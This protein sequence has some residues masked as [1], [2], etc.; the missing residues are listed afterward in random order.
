MVR[1]KM[2]VLMI[3]SNPLMVDPRVYKEAKTLVEEGYG[4]TVIVWDRHQEHELETTLDGIKIIRIHNKGLM[5]ILPNDIFRNP[6]WWR[7]AYRKGLKLYNSGYKFDVVH[8]HDLDTLQA[9]VWLKKKLGIK[10]IY[11][12]HELWGYLIKGNVP[13]FIVKKAF[14][15]E[16]KLTT[17]VDHII[18][19]SKP[20]KE[21]FHSISQ[22]PVTLVMN[23]KDLLYG[24]Y[25]PPG[26]DIFTLLYIGGMKKRR[27]FPQI[28]DIVGNLDNVRLVLGGKKEDMYF[29]MKKYSKK[30][31]NIEFIGTVPSN[32]IIP[33]TRNAD[34]TFII[35]DPNSIHY[36]NT[37]FNKQF[38][39][40]VCGRP[41][42][43]TKR[44]YAGEMTEGLKCGIVVEYTEE[45]VKKAILSL[46]DS[47]ELCKEL[48][49]NAF[50]AA[51]EKYNW[52]NE[53]RKLLKVYGEI[54]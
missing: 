26:N 33:L 49:K 30:Y 15:M 43:V 53:K 29:E 35:A 28:I 6:L 14:N 10:L 27:F 50:K 46:R 24:S 39:A 47:P 38:E 21:Y 18:T 48:G 41:I 44:I 31:D 1:K 54:L 17:R 8:C 52:K 9:G 51:K 23:C 22:K 25:T 19:V 11:D 40:M 2:K 32:E 45:S 3:L 42:I 12:A 36:Q 34:A 4:V 37:L 5:R 16:K 20:F 7:M 13:E